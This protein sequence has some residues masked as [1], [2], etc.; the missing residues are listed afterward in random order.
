M[1]E[2]ANKWVISAAAFW[3]EKNLC[4][5][6]FI[7]Y[8]LIL[9]KLQWKWEIWF[10]LWHLFVFSVAFVYITYWFQN[11]QHLQPL[12]SFLSIECEMTVVNITF[13]VCSM[14]GGKWCS[15]AGQDN[16]K[17]LS[18]ILVPI[19]EHHMAT[20]QEVTA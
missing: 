5:Y 2:R 17:S 10:F 7:L 11:S 18:T 4:I 12:H 6:A 3:N 9:V 20:I 19:N 15:W 8:T 1:D 14:G 16:L 13:I